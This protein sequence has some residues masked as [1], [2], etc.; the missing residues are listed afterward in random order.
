LAHC[1][2]IAPLLSAFND[3]ELSAQESNQVAKHL[4]GCEACKATVLDYLLLGHHLRSATALPPLDGFTER[5]MKGIGGTRRPLRGRLLNRIED[6][7]ER[8]VAAVSLMGTAVAVASLVLVLAEAHAKHPVAGLPNGSS[9]VSVANNNV[10]NNTVA[11]NNVANNGDVSSETSSTESFEPEPPA[12]E[13]YISRLEAKPSSVA[14]WSEPDTKTTVIWLA[15][16]SSGN[17]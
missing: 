14:T 4:D 15:D 8:W 7:R 6:L 3:G 13:A 17:D 16:D 9:T 11:G 10:A 1:D 5:V 12:G 2:D